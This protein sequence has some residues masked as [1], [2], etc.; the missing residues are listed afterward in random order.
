MKLA[1]YKRK[2][3]KTT[4]DLA[5]AFD[6]GHSTMHYWVTMGF[7]IKGLPGARRITVLKV[8][9]QEGGA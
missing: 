2:H 3:K 4:Q 7:D 6:V 8:M 9:A 5:A 1:D